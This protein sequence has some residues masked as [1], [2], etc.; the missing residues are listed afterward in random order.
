MPH[1][2]LID[3]ENLSSRHA[4]LVLAEVPADCAVL[5]VYG[6]VARL[7]GWLAVAGLRAVHVAP[8]RNA[9]DIALAVEAMVLSHDGFESFTLATGDGGLAFLVAHLRA[10]GRRVQ[11]VGNATTPQ[12][13]RA[14]AHRFVE[15]PGADAPGAQ[16]DE[17]KV[18]AAVRAAGPAGLPV[19]ELNHLAV[20]E[21]ILISQRPERTWRKWLLARPDRFVV[22][23][24]GPQARVRLAASAQFPV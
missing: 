9:A 18:V 10:T 20:R 24:R 23:P 12:A 11:V 1:A 14:A 6:D 15:L 17:S 2:L 21:R 13:L 4:P 8:G 16:T 22:D 7:N 19:A 5:R 3:G